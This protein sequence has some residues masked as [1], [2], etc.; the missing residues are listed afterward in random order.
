M[1]VSTSTRVAPTLVA[2]V[3]SSLPP[4]PT[5]AGCCCTKSASVPPSRQRGAAHCGVGTTATEPASCEAIATLAPPASE[6]SGGAGSCTIAGSGSALSATDAGRVA[7]GAT[8]LRA[9]ALPMRRRS[10]W[11]ARFAAREVRPSG[12]TATFGVSA[13][14]SSGPL[15]SSST[16]SS[17][18]AALPSASA[19]GRAMT[20]ESP[21][22]QAVE[23]ADAASD[24]GRGVVASSAATSVG[25]AEVAATPTEA[26]TL[27]LFCSSSRALSTTCST[28]NASWRSKTTQ[29]F[30]GGCS[31][32]THC[33]DFSSFGGRRLAPMGWSTARSAVG[34]TMGSSCTL[35]GHLTDWN[36]LLRGSP[37]GAESNCMEDNSGS[38]LWSKGWTSPL[39]PTC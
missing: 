21:S 17:T 26:S 32:S 27:P 18:A 7:T 39:T 2:P 37:P 15:A 34:T 36:P 14:P 13:G 22:P 10:R 31:S 24:A 29:D 4:T 6:P 25:A 8:S 12:A 19:V 38:F 30:A 33:H 23:A 20:L 28:S 35:C 16:S 11:R 5:F 3:A 9:R 1:F